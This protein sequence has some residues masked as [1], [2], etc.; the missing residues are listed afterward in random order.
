MQHTRPGR[1][2]P[3]TLP[4]TQPLSRPVRRL[5]SGQDSCPC[6]TSPVLPRTHREAVCYSKGLGA[7]ESVPSTLHTLFSEPSD[8]PYLVA[9]RNQ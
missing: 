3:A 1:S 4:Q 9:H 6:H 8:H 5:S 2:E 7:T